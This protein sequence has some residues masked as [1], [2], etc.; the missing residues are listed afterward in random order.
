LYICDRKD[1]AGKDV[2]MINAEG[3]VCD[4]AGGVMDKRGA[5]VSATVTYAGDSIAAAQT[6]AIAALKVAAGV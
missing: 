3:C 5:Q 2:R 4:S 6:A 1:D